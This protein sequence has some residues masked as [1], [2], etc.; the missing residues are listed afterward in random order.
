MAKKEIYEL[1]NRITSVN[2]SI[3]SFSNVI[4][5]IRYELEE[6]VKNRDNL[7]FL[8]IP[9]N[10]SFYKSLMWA[11]VGGLIILIIILFILFNRN[12]IITRQTSKEMATLRD[13][14]ENYRKTN[15][16]KM[17]KMVIEHFNEIKRIKGN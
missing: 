9:M 1:K 14:F 2:A 12:L 13:E 6:A 17:E 10:K 7:E 15:R 11:I 4:K 8:G 16:E 5:N 3:D